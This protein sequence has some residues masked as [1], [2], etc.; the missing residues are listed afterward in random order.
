MVAIS[1]ENVSSQP[2][3]LY[4]NAN[5]PNAGVGIGMLDKENL[6]V[7]GQLVYPADETA[8]SGIK[9]PKRTRL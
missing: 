9:Q 8:T 6:L 5:L 1:L 3:Y 4:S 7:E 2:S